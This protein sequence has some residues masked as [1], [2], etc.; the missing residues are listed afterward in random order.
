MPPHAG[1]NTPDSTQLSGVKMKRN[2]LVGQVF[3]RLTVQYVAGLNPKQNVLWHCACACGGSTIALAYDLRRG[4]VKSC[5]CLP[6]EGLNTTHGMARTGKKRSRIYSVWSSML[7]RCNN[8]K[9]RNYHNYGGRGIKVCKRWEKFE[10]FLADM[11]EPAKGMTLDRKNNDKGYSPSNCRWAS[12][13]EQSRNRRG[14]I[15]VVL[16]GQRTLLK[17]ALDALGKTRQ[18]LY[19]QMRTYGLTHQEGVSKWQQQ[20][21][22]L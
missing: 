10:L 9:D 4:R 17:D 1:H 11:G 20:K 2:D 5:G 3:E 13:A 15:W 12:Y 21:K 18:A 19:H 22:R 16:G 14:N 6:R 8:P 7:A